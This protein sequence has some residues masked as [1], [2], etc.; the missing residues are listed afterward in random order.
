MMM[1][2][3]RYLKHLP[4]RI[5]ISAAPLLRF[6]AA[7]FILLAVVLFVAGATIQKGTHTSTAAH[8]QS[9]S[10]SSY[11]ALQ[12]TITQRFGAWV[13]DPVLSSVLGLPAYLLFGG[14]AGLCGIAGRR[15]RVVNIYVN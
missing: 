1:R 14:L 9:V 7:L 6:L 12:G 10:P 8:W 5:A 4:G 13:W 11:A 2:L 3:I 15:R